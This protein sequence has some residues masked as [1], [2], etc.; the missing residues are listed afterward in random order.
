MSVLGIL[1]IIVAFS[2]LVLIHELGHYLAAKWMGVRV[3]K[4]SI[5]FPPTLFTKKIG[6]TE[7]CFSAIPLGGY[8]KMAGFIDESMDTKLTGADYEYSSKPVWKRIIIITAGVVMNL[9]LAVI[10]YTFLNFSQGEQILPTTT[11]KLT[12]QS[13][14]AEKIGFRDG[15]KI[16][17]VNGQDVSNFNQII[18]GFFDNMENGVSFKVLR[19]NQVLSLNYNKEWLSENKGELLDISPVIDSRVGDV[20]QEMPAAKLGLKKG[21]RII[22]LNGLAIKS[23]QDMTEIIRANPEKAV[24]IKWVHDGTVKTG[25]IVP[26]M[27]NNIDEDGKDVSYGQIGITYY[28]I[29][30][31]ISFGKA[32]KLGIIQPFSVILLNIKGLKWWISGVKT[33]KETI[34]GPVTIA[35]LAGEAAEKGWVS[36]LSI[37]AALSS[38]LAF[39]NILPIPALDGGHLSFLLVEAVMGKPLSVKTRLIIQQVGMALLLTFIIFVLYVDFDRILS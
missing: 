36:Y 13:G 7:F 24:D 19:D 2:V 30:N 11:I 4:F 16:L 14:I 8:V 17:A 9:I 33:A 37:L 32:V 39:F 23:F 5:G 20:M 31:S 34:G 27:V 35:R 10:L 21:D 1:A 6:E 18:T 12:N 3:E 15:D 28:Y 26:K 29:H 25:Q 22:E 38:V